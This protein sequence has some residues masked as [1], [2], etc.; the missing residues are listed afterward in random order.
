MLTREWNGIGGGV[1][2]LKLKKILGISIN[3]ARKVEHSFQNWVKIKLC[4]KHS[5]REVGKIQHLKI[6]VPP[7]IKTRNMKSKFLPFPPV[8]TPIFATS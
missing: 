8:N 4:E 5:A 3:E 1:H 6:E 7:A 2:F